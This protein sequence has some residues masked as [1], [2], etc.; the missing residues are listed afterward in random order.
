MSRWQEWGP[1]ERKGC[2]GK[3]RLYHILCQECYLA[4]SP[5]ARRQLM[6]KDRFSGARR[7]RLRR[8]VGLGYPL[9]KIDLGGMRQAG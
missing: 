3:C 1:C 4:L 9:E 6:I 8:L 7:E 5:I 2:A